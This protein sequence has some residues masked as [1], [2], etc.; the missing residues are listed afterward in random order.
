MKCKTCGF[1]NMDGANFCINCGTRLGEEQ[2]SKKTETDDQKLSLMPEQTELAVVDEDV[3]PAQILSETVLDEEPADE[4]QE[5]EEISERSFVLVDSEPETEPEQAKPDQADSLLDLKKD[6]QSDSLKEL[7]DYLEEPVEE[8]QPAAQPE[9]SPKTGSEALWYYVSGDD[10]T[11]PFTVDEMFEKIRMGVITDNTYVWSKGLPDWIRLSQSALKK[12]EEPVDL[13]KAAFSSAS[14]ADFSSPAENSGS[15]DLSSAASKLKSTAAFAAG[16]AASAAASAAEHLRSY[17]DKQ[18]SDSGTE[19]SFQNQ[20]AFASQNTASSQNGFGPQS[21]EASAQWFCVQ[22]NRS[23][24][25]YNLQTITA[26]LANGQI[27]GSTYVWKEG[28]SDWESLQNTELRNCMSQNSYSSTAWNQST[29]NNN[30]MNE[31]Q[32]GYTPMNGYVTK[33]SIVL[34][35]LLSLITCGIWDL[36][37]YYQLAKDINTLAER[38]NRPKG[39]DPVMTVL[40][41]IVTCSLYRFY[42]FWK[43]GTTLAQISRPGYPNTDQS[44]LLTLLG[45]ICPMAS[46]AIMQDQVNSYVQ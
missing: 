35:I 23:T 33:K 26:M 19:A 46:L 37:W 6:S 13:K 10:S 43:E 3:L 2:E 39:C 38:Q 9:E 30:G 8:I 15:K 16:A 28:M 32:G 27:N 20:S 29:W 34:Y 18:P 40:L 45:F 42:Y 24:G 31:Q 41:E 36:V 4:K 17:A 5:P 1:D 7:E 11:G 44:L 22:D 12:Q 21:S 14:S 25:P